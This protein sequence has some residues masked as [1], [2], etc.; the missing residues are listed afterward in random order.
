MEVYNSFDE[1]AKGTGALETGTGRTAFVDNMSPKFTS[2]PP[3]HG[4]Q[5]YVWADE[6]AHGGKPEKPHV[7]I[8]LPEGEIKCWI[9]EGPNRNMV[10]PDQTN[11]H[12]DPR[13]MNEVASHRQENWK[14]VAREWNNFIDVNYPAFRDDEQCKI[15]IDGADNG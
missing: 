9:S 1:M 14:N 3:F 4:K 13:I 7:H 10:K 11:L 15:P 12:I 5:F 8:K 6:E 2:I